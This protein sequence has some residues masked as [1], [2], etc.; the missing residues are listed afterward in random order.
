MAA[1]MT[2][3]LVARHIVKRYPNVLAVQ[4]VSCE[5][6]GGEVLAVIG[7]NGAGKTTLF[8]VVAGEQRP[9]RGKV[10]AFGHDVTGWSASRRARLGI[11]RTFQV[12]RLFPD[13]TVWG[14]V[15]VAVDAAEGSWSHGWNKF[16][17]RRGP[18]RRRVSAALD[19]A[20]LTEL[21]GVRANSLSHGDKKRLELAMALAQDPVLLLLDEPTAGMS[22]QDAQST[23]V[24]LNKIHAERPGLSMLITAHDMEVVFGTASR[25]LLMAEGQIVLSGTPAEVAMDEKTINLYLGQEWRRDVTAPES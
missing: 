17:G 8:N 6:A 21:A 20:G 13:S 15:A 14:N 2:D 9:N 12:S 5:V 10:E 16:S 23:V 24:L 11:A 3:V 1:A 4:D 25:V 19:E 22:Y 18:V 7:P